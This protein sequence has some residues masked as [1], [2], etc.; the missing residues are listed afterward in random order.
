MSSP[1]V[2]RYLDRIGLDP[3]RSPEHDRAGLERLQRAHVTSI[4]FETLAVTGDPFDRFEGAGVS[5]AIDDLSEKIVE[6]GRGG[7]CYELNE[8]FARLLDALG[9][10]VT[11]VAARMVGGSGIPAAHRS[12]L[13]SLESSEYVVDVGMGTPTMRR[14]TPLPDEGGERT[15]SGSSDRPVTAAGP[16]QVDTVGVHWRAVAVDRPDA[17]YLTQYREPGD[18]DWSDRYLF[19]TTPREPRYFGATREYLVTAP[20]SPFTGEP[21]ASIATD[22]GHVKLRPDALIRT[23]GRERYERTITSGEWDA[24]LGS[25]FGIDVERLVN[26]RS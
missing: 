13:V 1:S 16:P 26:R 14:P 22:R 12:T 6:R 15:D 9:F 5:V 8:L 10:D 20:E 3:D 7:F 24:L 17:T 18:D 19:D 23:A 25:E 4:P 11:G 2:A 21:V